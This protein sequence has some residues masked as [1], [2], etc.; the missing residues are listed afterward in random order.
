MSF[1]RKADDR[2]FTDPNQKRRK[3]KEYKLLAAAIQHTYGNYVWCTS[4]YKWKLTEAESEHHH[5]IRLQL[6][7]SD[8]LLADSDLVSI[9]S[10]TDQPVWTKSKMNI[11]QNIEFIFLIEPSQV[12]KEFRLKF[13]KENEY[14]EYSIYKIR[15]L[16]P[17]PQILGEK[18]NCAICMD[19]VKENLKLITPCHHLFCLPCLFEYSRHKQYLSPCECHAHFNFN[20]TVKCPLCRS[21]F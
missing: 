9:I 20:T 21:L 11:K 12:G 4:E 10:P 6:R 14:D 5:L 17:P 8:D 13:I 2:S 16:V 1:K 15:F 3:R 7:L 18:K 19:D